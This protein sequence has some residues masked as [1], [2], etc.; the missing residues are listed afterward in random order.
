MNPE[1]SL[2]ICDWLGLLSN[3]FPIIW[4][5]LGGIDRG[6]PNGEARVGRVMIL[7]LPSSIESN[8]RRLALIRGGG[9]ANA[10]RGRLHLGGRTALMA[11]VLRA[12]ENAW[13]Q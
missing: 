5:L 1:N 13:W 11:Q 2:G 6:R 4:G 3:S 7:A 12:G 9:E 10:G 8:R